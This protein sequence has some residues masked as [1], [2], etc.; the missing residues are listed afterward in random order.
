MDRANNKEL[1]MKVKA[2]ADTIYARPGLY[3]SA[4][5]QKEYQRQGGTYKGPKPDKNKGVQRWLLG[6][7]WIEVMPYLK[8]NKIVECGTTPNKGKACRPLIRINKDTPITIP[9]LLKIH[10]K[11][12]LIKIVKQKELDMDGRVNW[13]A[14]TFRKSK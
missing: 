3:K 2:K 5:I 13:K 14:G 7:E 11:E 8:N 4:Y 10:S 12:K 6:E 1:Y 9:E